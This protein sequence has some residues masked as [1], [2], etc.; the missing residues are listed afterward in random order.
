MKNSKRQTANVEL[1]D[2]EVQET[3]LSKPRGLKVANCYKQVAGCCAYFLVATTYRLLQA[4]YGA[5]WRGVLFQ[6]SKAP[7]RGGR[8]SPFDHSRA[9]QNYARN[10]V[11]DEFNLKRAVVIYHPDDLNRCCRPFRPAQVRVKAAWPYHRV[12]SLY[13][14]PIMTM[15]LRRRRRIFSSYISLE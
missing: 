4:H 3:V 10:T 9:W 14:K 1:Y 8:Q 15:R 11:R 13:R 5:N 12:M 7:Q 6:G 2:H